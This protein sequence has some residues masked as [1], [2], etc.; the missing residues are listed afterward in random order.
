MGDNKFQD[1]IKANYNNIKK[2]Q[3][4]NH[5]TLSSLQQY[6]L[7]STNNLLKKHRNKVKALWRPKTISDSY[8]IIHYICRKAIIKIS[9]F[10]QQ[11]HNK[12][13]TDHQLQCALAKNHKQNRQITKGNPMIH[14]RNI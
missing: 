3:D 7:I 4:S 6:F 8:Y 1:K 9:L 12:Q 2:T 10:Q 11:K 13:K 5:K 14:I